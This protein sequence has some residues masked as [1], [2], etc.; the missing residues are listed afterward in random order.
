MSNAEQHLKVLLQAIAPGILGGHRVKM[1]FTQ[2]E[3]DAA[4][5]WLNADAAETPAAAP[6]RDET[7]TPDAD[8][9]SDETRGVAARKRGKR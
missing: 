8:A 6:P 7:P 4:L 9:A 2:D 5:A 1:R 3:L